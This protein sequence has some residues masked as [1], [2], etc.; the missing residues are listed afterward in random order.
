MCADDIGKIQDS[1]HWNHMWSVGTVRS[2]T[3]R[4]LLR[5]FGQI[6]A[7]FNWI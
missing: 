4:L 1:V 5:T 2:G 7:S 3:T 6:C